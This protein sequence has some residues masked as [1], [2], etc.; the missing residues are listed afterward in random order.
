MKALKYSFLVLLM[1]FSTV[2]C[3]DFLDV[4][5]NPNVPQA[6]PAHLILAP[7][8]TAMARAIH[9]DSRNIGKY[10][11]YWVHTTAGEVWD[12]H[13]YSSGSDL[14]GECWRQHYF[15]VGKN[16]D[17]MI[18]DARS[19]NL[20]SYIGIAYAIRAWG[21]QTIA[22]MHGDAVI[23][24]EAFN[25][26]L[27]SFNYD[28]QE[29]A[30][31]ESNRL[32]DSAL[33]YLDSKGLIDPNLASADQAFGGDLTKWKKFTNGILA[34]NFHRLT[35][36]GNYSADKVI[37]YCDAAMASNT[38]NFSIPFNGTKSDDANFFGTLR[39]NLRVYRASKFVVSLLDGKNPTMQGVADP[40]LRV[41]LPPNVGDTAMT[42]TGIDPTFGLATGQ[43]TPNLWGSTTVNPAST[44]VLGRWLFSDKARFPL[45]TYSELQLIK[46]E[47]QMR[48]ADKAGALVSYKKAID[49]HIDFTNSFASIAGNA[50]TTPI[51]AAQKTAFLANTK[52]VPV[53]ADS[54]TMDQ[55][56]LQKYV[57]CW[58]W[59][60][61]ETWN[62]MR[63][64]HYG[65]DKFKGETVYTGFTPPAS[66]RL[67]A[68]NGG[69]LAYNVRPRYN[70]EYIWN[71][72]A[73][74][75]IG[76]FDADYHTR[77]PWFIKP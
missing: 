3:N 2:S 6:A 39:D 5:T 27:L 23:V 62:D 21:W 19:R 59:G 9:F 53:I 32:C 75:K 1:A 61:L 30:Y 28:S 77:E 38:D 24:K 42:V 14:G 36:K 74:E 65:A 64:F 51:T 66:G 76:G 52:I 71:R 31:A 56:M 57:A 11:Q 34:R 15:G 55:I 29:I 49:A 17:L 67:F 50:P 26:D 41:M 4:N 37:A 43:I 44:G 73:L 35:N 68:A 20:P 58:G 13:G 60:F 18:D 72:A 69:K 47:A 63:R 46:A 54:L 10:T 16:V 33:F 25:Q 7:M 8:Y 45:M 70:S 40:R 22:D 48:K 12:Q